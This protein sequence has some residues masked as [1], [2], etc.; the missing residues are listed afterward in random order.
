ML[1]SP[2]FYCIILL[3]LFSC[4]EKKT[5]NPKTKSIQKEAYALRDKAIENYKNQNF[6]TAFYDF[7]KS[8][9]LYETLKDSANIGYILIQ[10]SPL[11]LRILRE[12]G[13]AV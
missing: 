4:E 5:V 3:F 13:N 12:L 2:F 11:F 9:K 7:N 1:R 10:M 6:N 8:K